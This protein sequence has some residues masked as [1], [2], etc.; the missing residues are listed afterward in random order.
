MVQVQVPVALWLLCI[1]QAKQ[2]G[3]TWWAIVL[4][5]IFIHSTKLLIEKLASFSPP[6]PIINTPIE[7]VEKSF[8]DLLLVLSPTSSTSPQKTEDTNNNRGWPELVRA[9]VGIIISVYVVQQICWDIMSSSSSD[10]SS[11]T[12]LVLAGGRSGLVVIFLILMGVIDY[13][14][15]T[16]K[17]FLALIFITAVSGVIWRESDTITTSTTTQSTK[18]IVSEWLQLLLSTH[19]VLVGYVSTNVPITGDLVIR[20]LCMLAVVV[21]APLSSGASEKRCLIP[22]LLMILP[23][24]CLKGKQSVS[25]CIIPILDCICQPELMYPLTDSKKIEARN[26]LVVQQKQEILFYIM[27]WCVLLGLWAHIRPSVLLWAQIVGGI[28]YLAS[29]R[30]YSNVV[31]ILSNGQGQP[32]ERTPE[33][34]LSSESGSIF[35]NM[36]FMHSMRRRATTTISPLQEIKVDSNPKNSNAGDPHHHHNTILT[37]LMQKSITVTNSAKLPP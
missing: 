23:A 35:N 26:A 3:A 30:R 8:F 11:F 37:K 9:S 28:M 5:I 36:M 34:S 31:R 18:F 33:G 32:H 10:A 14:S 22:S 2:V 6:Q 25:E 27:A 7:S 13:Q 16:S 20:N 4:V 21:I 29:L 1:W 15:P 17:W 24:L 12:A 19:A